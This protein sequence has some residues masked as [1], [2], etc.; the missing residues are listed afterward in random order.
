MAMTMYEVGVASPLRCMKCENAIDA[1][2][3]LHVT[4]EPDMKIPK[5][6]LYTENELSKVTTLQRH[7]T[8]RITRPHS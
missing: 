7:V 4:Y 5:T 1:V 3:L 8:D 6:C 2:F